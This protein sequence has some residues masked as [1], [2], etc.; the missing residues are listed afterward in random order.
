MANMSDTRVKRC[1]GH[2][3]LLQDFC[4]FVLFACYNPIGSLPVWG[5]CGDG[6]E[7]V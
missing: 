2:L 4:L 6:E 3:G 5:W 7:A 1:P